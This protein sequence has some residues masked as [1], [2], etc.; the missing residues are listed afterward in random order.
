MGGA[1]SRQV[2][3]SRG[4]SLFP[5]WGLWEAGELIAGVFLSQMWWTKTRILRQQNGPH[6]AHGALQ[7]DSRL[8]G[9]L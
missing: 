5:C 4:S 3:V 1:L 7:H 8:H 9:A 2:A 6:D